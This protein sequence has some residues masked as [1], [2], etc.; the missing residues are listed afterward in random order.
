MEPM[1]AALLTFG[2]AILVCSWVLLIIVSFKEDFTWGLCSVF[3]PALA[4]FY[5]LF[6]WSKAKDVIWLAVLGWVLLFF[7]LI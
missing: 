7:A 5:A 3:A 4:Y 1:S 6:Q 2:L